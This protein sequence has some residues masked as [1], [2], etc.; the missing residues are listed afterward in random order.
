MKY[1][2]EPIFG[3]NNA[4]SCGKYTGTCTFV[5]ASCADFPFCYNY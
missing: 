5:D 1:L 2:V 4:S 3:I